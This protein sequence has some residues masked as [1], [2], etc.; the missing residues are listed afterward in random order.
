VIVDIV[1]GWKVIS[2]QQWLVV[3]SISEPGRHLGQRISE[4]LQFSLQ[5]A[6]GMLQ[7]GLKV[8]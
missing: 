2:I 8:L 3:P 6:S 5:D 7:F 4:N 1:P